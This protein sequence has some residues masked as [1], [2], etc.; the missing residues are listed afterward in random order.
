MLS[1]LNSAKIGYFGSSTC[2]ASQSHTSLLLTILLLLTIMAVPT[3]LFTDVSDL[4]VSDSSS[5]ILLPD[6]T[7]DST[8]SFDSYV[9]LKNFFSNYAM[10]RGWNTVLY[11]S[12]TATG[13]QHHGSFKCSLHKLPSAISESAVPTDKQRKKRARRVEEQTGSGCRWQ[14]CWRRTDREPFKWNVTTKRHLEH[15][16]HQPLGIDTACRVDQS[17]KFTAEMIQVLTRL[18]VTTPSITETCAIKFMTDQFKVTFSPNVFHYQMVLTRK[19]QQMPEDRQEMRRLFNFFNTQK[20]QDRCWARMAV[21]EEMVTDRI[22]YISKAMKYN[23]ERNGDLIIM[24]TTCKTNRFGLPLLV[25]VGVN[26]YYHTVILAVAVIAHETADMFTWALQAVRDCVGMNVWS[27]VKCIATDGDAA[28]QLAI[29]NVLP[30]A[31]HLRCTYHLEQNIRSNMKK[32]PMRANEITQL[33]EQWQNVIYEPDPQ[34]HMQLRKRLHDNYPAAVSYLE[35][36]IW[37]NAE[38]FVNA[39]TRQYLTLGMYSTQRV[40]SMHASLKKLFD[41]R[42][43]TD[44]NSLFTALEQ[45]SI[46]QQDRTVEDALKQQIQTQQSLNRKA[47]YTRV[48][49]VCSPYISNLICDEWDSA[50]SYT[51]KVSRNETNLCMEAEVTATS[52]QSSSPSTSSTACYSPRTVFVRKDM[53][54]CTCMFPTYMLLPCRHVLLVNQHAFGSNWQ[55]DQVAV[56][57]NI[58]HM[59]AIPAAPS[60]YVATTAT[61]LDNNNLV[62]LVPMNKGMTRSEAFS[63]LHNVGKELATV[64]SERMHYFDVAHST[65]LHMIKQAKTCAV[66]PVKHRQVT[67]NKENESIA[68]DDVPVLLDPPTF[69]H[70]RQK[71]LSNAGEKQPNRRHETS[72]NPSL[73][74]AAINIPLP[75]PLAMTDA[76]FLMDS[77]PRIYTQTLPP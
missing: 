24:D 13:Q 68:E 59:S 71:R 70:K 73:L 11:A 72:I 47:L 30:H 27:R 14:V 52:N 44:I 62:K 67:D 76:Q 33:I 3:L 69:I 56:R 10:Q 35:K 7:T 75:V 53:C 12:G 55:S 25:L 39:C 40:E 32:V 22:V 18:V 34:T 16:G 63:T 64:V 65:L 36:N 20:E 31:K 46:R 2:A 4:S 29:N 51:V 50:G 37:P 74:S 57:W 8:H 21:D 48:S 28:M 42:S 66:T 60:S 6:I 61:T 58:N 5:G 19:Q 17:K 26:Q 54:S 9:G 1:P 38:L 77:V 23:L 43:T 15:T 45:A 41:L 49:L